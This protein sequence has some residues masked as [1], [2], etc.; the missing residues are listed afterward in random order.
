MDPRN[1]A[2]IDG[3]YG[4]MHEHSKRNWNDGTRNVKIQFGQLGTRLNNGKWTEQQQK[5]FSEMV[6]Q[7]YAVMLQRLNILWLLSV[8]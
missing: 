1:K 6:A 4:K 2:T 8:M 5:H 3:T 7:T